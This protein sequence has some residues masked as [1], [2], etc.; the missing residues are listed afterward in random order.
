MAGIQI[1]AFRFFRP[2]PQRLIAHLSGLP[3]K[4][5]TDKQD[6][7]YKLYDCCGDDVKSETTNGKRFTSHV[8]PFMAVDEWDELLDR[9]ILKIWN[10]KGLPEKLDKAMVQAFAAEFVKALME[11]LGEFTDTDSEPNKEFIDRLTNDVWQFSAAKT[12]QQMKDITQL[13]VDGAGKLRTYRDFKFEAGKINEEYVGP[14]LQ[15]EYN[16]AVA[17]SQMGA[18]WQTIWKDKK[19][20]PYL[21]YDTVGDNRVRP[22]HQ[23][24]EGIIRRVDDPFWKTHFPPNG[25]NC[26]CD[27]RQLDE[28]IETDLSKLSIPDVPPMFL[29]NAGIEGMIFP[30]NHPYYD[31]LPKNISKQVK[32]I[33]L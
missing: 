12:Y 20:L 8:S 23:Q 28:G 30:K 27:V 5:F 26:R 24:M 25:W 31:G 32:E 11:G 13:L 14:W 33:Q 7:L 6:E 29:F 21:R 2:R 17:A 10:E 18:K 16:N 22:D 1:M 3:G 15:A 19:A 4:S 9:L